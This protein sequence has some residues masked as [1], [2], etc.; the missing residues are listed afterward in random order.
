MTS[1]IIAIVLLGLAVGGV[2]IRK[3]YY[4]LPLTELKRRA[5][6]DIFAA[7][8]YQAAAYESSLQVILW[9]FIASTSAGGFVLLARVAPIWLSL[10]TVVL[11]LL[12]SFSWLP[13]SRVTVIGARA[14][15]WLSP[16]LSRL[17][18]FLHPIL[19]RLVSLVGRRYAL[20]PH[21][22]LFEREDLLQLLRQ[23]QAQKDSRLS[24]EQLSIVMHVLTFS[25][26]HV[27]DV[28]TPRGT[29]RTVHANET[30]GPILIDELHQT[31]MEHIIVQDSPNA[32]IVGTLAVRDLGLHSSGRVRDVM[33]PTVYY[34]HE[35]DNLS[36]ALHAFFV[37]NHSL[38]VVTNSFEEY[39]GVLSVSSLLHE[40]LGHVP[41]EAFD[42][43]ADLQA[44]A[45]R[46]PRVKR[47]KKTDDI[48]PEVLK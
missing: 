42:Q 25:D 29:M 37:T 44:V 13:A 7:K 22:G 19:Q 41:G 20:P 45:N 10:V 24:V 30:V 5:R 46:H 17:L 18:S 2:A 31:G 32:E 11:V 9:L 39:V 6:H 48:A 28:L 16:L 3:T 47:G 26:H 36:D 1:F 4:S 38:F 12:V 40:L 33:D 43:Y 35:S 34:V 21:T 23:Q 27:R 8:L 14:T 15:M